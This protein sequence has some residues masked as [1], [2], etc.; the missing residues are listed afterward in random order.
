MILLILFNNQATLRM[1]QLYFGI[2]NVFPQF[3]VRSNISLT[4]LYKWRYSGQVKA[5]MR[6]SF[7]FL[8]ALHPGHPAPLH[9]LPQRDDP[10]G[11][12]HLRGPEAPGDP[13]RGGPDPHLGP[14]S[15]APLPG[16]VRRERGGTVVTSLIP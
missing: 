12:G 8:G 9:L 2:C 4:N 5:S 13:P 3:K 10:L 15:P 6:F 16:Q 7:V 1:T 11:E 14:R